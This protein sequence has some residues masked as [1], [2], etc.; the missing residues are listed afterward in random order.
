MKILITIIFFLSFCF[1]NSQSFWINTGL[2]AD[3]KIYDKNINIYPNPANETLTIEWSEIFFPE[4]I[5]IIDISGKE[6]YH[7]KNLKF[8]NKLIINMLLFPKGIYFIK[9]KMNS[10]DMIIKKVVII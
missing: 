2:K 1:L 6:Y 4:N 10:G 9:F 7:Q 8:N 3:N 5:Y